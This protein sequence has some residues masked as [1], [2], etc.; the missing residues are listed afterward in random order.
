MVH[1]FG[2]DLELSLVGRV[3]HATEYIRCGSISFIV[4]L[5]HHIFCI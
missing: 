2:S 4:Q 5:H 3:V 1:M